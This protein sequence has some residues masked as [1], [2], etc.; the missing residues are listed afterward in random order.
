MTLSRPAQNTSH[1]IKNITRPGKAIRIFQTNGL[2]YG[3]VS[4]LLT[5][6]ALKRRSFAAQ[7]PKIDFI[8]FQ[9]EF[10][11]RLEPSQTSEQ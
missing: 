2:D 9:L 5:Q 3:F 6:K 4:W 10:P 8:A 11:H 1:Q 7:N